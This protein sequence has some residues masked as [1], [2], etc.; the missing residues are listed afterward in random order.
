MWTYAQ[1]GSQPVC[2][3]DYKYLRMYRFP[4]HFCLVL[5]PVFV[6]ATETT[7]AKLKN[8]RLQA[9]KESPVLIMKRRCQ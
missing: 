7:V 9:L 8:W 3:P 6:D 1:L 4:K 2:A 5:S